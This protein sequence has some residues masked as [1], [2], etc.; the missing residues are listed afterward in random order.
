MTDASL[1]PERQMNMNWDGSWN[2]RT[3][4][5]DDGWSVEY[6]VPWSMMP[7]PESEAT[8]KIGFY[9]ERQVGSI[10]GEAWSTP[11]AEDRQ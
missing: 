9:F 2:G 3:Q 1:L 5:L 6:F 8:R 4:A 10:G 7:L 11:P